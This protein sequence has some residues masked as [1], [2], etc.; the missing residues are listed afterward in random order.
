V[1]EQAN[2][3]AAAAEVAGGLTCHES[4]SRQDH[5][6][7]R[8]CERRTGPFNILPTH[9]NPARGFLILYPQFYILTSIWQDI[10]NGQK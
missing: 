9:I 2:R 5:S 1:T 10:I 7:A 3:L 4:L 8:R 6:S